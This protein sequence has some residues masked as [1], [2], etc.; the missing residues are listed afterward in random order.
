MGRYRRYRIARLEREILS[1]EEA[2]AR[3]RARVERL[4]DREYGP[5]EPMPTGTVCAVCAC[6]PVRGACFCEGAMRLGK[7]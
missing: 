2:L 7:I 6:R 3:K 1:D 4:L 5:R